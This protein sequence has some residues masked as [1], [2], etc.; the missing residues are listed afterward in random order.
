MENR[1][2]VLGIDFDCITLEESYKIFLSFIEGSSLKTI[3]TPNPEFIINSRKDHDFRRILNSGDLILPDGIGVI[4]CSRILG[5]AIR[6]RVS[7]VDL[8][9]RILKGSDTVPLSVFILGSTEVNCRDAINNINK[10]YPD[11]K[12]L[13][14]QNGY[15]DLR[16][17]YSISERI[18]SMRPDLLLV[19]LGSPRAEY[20]IDKYK[21]VLNNVK[22]AIGVGGTVDVLSGNTKLAPS[23]IRK[24]GFEWLY[25]IIKEP[26]RI[27]R[28][29]K[30]PLVLIY[31]VCERFG[32]R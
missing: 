19:A 15:Y 20:F 26:T 12:I 30:L 7:G 14:Y 23:S 24:A 21:D 9:L 29:I 5:K 25:R 8:V 3:F 18:D 32:K 16:D 4:L 2:T 17:E 31:A 10:K 13:G 22:C 6:H 1:Q 27:K 11:A 28:A